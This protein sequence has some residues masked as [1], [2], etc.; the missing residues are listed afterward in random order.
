MY[1]CSRTASYIPSINPAKM[2]L[3]FDFSV[4]KV[5]HTIY[6]KRE[7]AAGLDLVWDAFIKAEILDRWVAPK[8]WRL[9][10]SQPGR[11]ITHPGHQ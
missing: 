6:I 5:S 7:F 2:D 3:L 9:R 1:I 10:Y 8:P 4:D 11:A